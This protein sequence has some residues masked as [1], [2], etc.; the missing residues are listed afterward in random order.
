MTHPIPFASKYIKKTKII[1]TQS[2]LKYPLTRLYGHCAKDGQQCDERNRRTATAQRCTRPPQISR[3]ASHRDRSG[4][5]TNHT[6]RI[7]YIKWAARYY[8]NQLAL[9]QKPATTPLRATFSTHF[10]HRV[11]EKFNWRQA[12]Y[13]SV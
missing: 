13:F 10:K 9:T 5:C 4:T 3:I 1:H 7:I 8:Y 2:Q 6:F 12:T 11:C